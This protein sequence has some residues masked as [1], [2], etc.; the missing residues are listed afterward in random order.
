[1]LDSEETSSILKND[2]FFHLLLFSCKFVCSEENNQSGLRVFVFVFL[3]WALM[4]L[5][6][7]TIVISPTESV[8]IF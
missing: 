1:L 6:S 3:V 8:E 4:L 2:A 7:G 5:V